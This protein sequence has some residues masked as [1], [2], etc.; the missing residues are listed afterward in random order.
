MT[1]TDIYDG[2]KEA[3]GLTNK[4]L[5]AISQSQLD[6]DKA[7]AR[8]TELENENATL[9]KGVADLTAKASDFTAQIA[10]AKTEIESTKASVE[11]QAAARALEIVA[12]QGVPANKNVPSAEAANGADPE[13]ESI[14]KMMGMAKMVAIRE[15]EA[16]HKQS[17][18]K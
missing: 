1:I 18:T 11:K 14:K 17:W 10:T 7:L 5:D 13:K 16:S 6:R 2:L 3:I 15:W 4:K 8:V 9:R 12:A